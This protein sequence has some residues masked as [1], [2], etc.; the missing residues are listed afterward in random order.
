MQATRTRRLSAALRAGYELP[1]HR[2]AHRRRPGRP[3]R[4]RRPG[5]NG[6]GRGLRTPAHLRLLHLRGSRGDDRGVPLQE[7]PHD[8]HPACLGHR[9]RVDRPR[10]HQ[11]RHHLLRRRLRFDGA[12]CAVP[13]RGL[14]EPHGFRRGAPDDRPLQLRGEQVPAHG[15]GHLRHHR[16]LPDRLLRLRHGVLRDGHAPVLQHPPTIQVGRPLRSRLDPR[17]RDRLP[18][19]LHRGLGRHHRQLDDLGPLHQ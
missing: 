7:A 8:H 17:S 19:D 5:R 2:S 16:R 14:A 18:G 15:V 6:G 12:G 11:G 9:C 4:V 13:V 1:V 10:T 3:E